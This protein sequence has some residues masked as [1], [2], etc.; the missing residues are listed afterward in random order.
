MAYAIIAS[1]PGGTEVLR[2]IDMDLPV[3]SE[4]DVL[5]RQTAVGK[6]TIMGSLD[7]LKTFGTLVNFGQ[8]SGVPHQFRIAH[9]SQ[10]SFHLTRPVLFHFTAKRDWLERAAQELFNKVGGGAVKINIA[11]TLPLIKAEEAHQNLENRLTTGST[12]LIHKTLY[13]DRC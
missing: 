2:K 1:E 4:T 3:P 5:I 6:D 11:N 12:V 8:S 9:L 10:G 7:C 13:R